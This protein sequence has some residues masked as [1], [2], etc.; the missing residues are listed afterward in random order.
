MKLT[1][2]SYTRLPKIHISDHYCSNQSFLNLIKSKADLQIGDILLNEDSDDG[3]LFD[4]RVINQ[5][6]CLSDFIG[7]DNEQFGIP[8]WVFELGMKHNFSFESLKYIYT[9]DIMTTDVCFFIYPKSMQNK[10]IIV[11][12]DGYITSELIIHYDGQDTMLDEDLYIQLNVN[13]PMYRHI[14]LQD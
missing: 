9:E 13:L 5:D 4:I 10:E 2:L 11:N 7:L 14:F 3:M 12:K 8:A 6:G 1:N